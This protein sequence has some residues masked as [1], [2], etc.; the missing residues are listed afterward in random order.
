MTGPRRRRPAAVD[1]LLPALLDD[2]RD[3]FGRDLVGVYLC[4]SAVAGGFDPACSDLDLV[5]VSSFEASEIDLERLDR[6]H[7]RF[8]RRH[9]EWVDRMDFVYVGRRAL[10]AP[11]SE[12][13]TVA[14]ISHD[15]P[16]QIVP[17]RGW[18]L[19]WYQLQEGHDVLLG[20]PVE[21]LFAPIARA[22]FIR[23]LQRHV[24]ALGARPRPADLPAGTL[25]YR[26][27]TLGRAL[28]TFATGTDSTKSEGAEYA[29]TLYPEYGAVV[30]E[31]LRV[32]RLGGR[33]GFPAPLRGDADR[34]IERLTDDARAALSRQTMR[35]PSP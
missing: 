35:A 20:P 7:Q 17:E 26:V 8:A 22:E 30:S 19:T 11:D 18:I 9:P 3:F 21:Q 16:L 12:G 10:A 23:A 2:W 6:V 33:S 28:R 32:R 1:P 31:A 14:T 34:L 25:S 4:G 5:L 27:L 15:E 29:R 24:V 13:G